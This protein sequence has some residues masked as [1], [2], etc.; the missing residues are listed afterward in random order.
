MIYVASALFCEAKPYIDTLGLKKD[1]AFSKIQVFKNDDV[2]L[3][4][5]GTGI[6]ASAMN[7][8]FV[9]G[10]YTPF[11][12][13]VFL[14]T[15]IC[16][17][18]DIG[19]TFVCNKVTL[20]SDRSRYFCPD[21]LYKTD[22]EER[23]LVTFDKPAAHIYEN[24]LADTEGYGLAAA[25]APYFSAERMFF[26]KTVSDRGDFEKVTPEYVSYLIGRNVEKILELVHSLPKP[27]AVNGL[28]EDE[29]REARKLRLSVSQMQRLENSLNYYRLKGG[30]ALALLRACPAA[31]TKQ[32]GRDILEYIEKTVI[33]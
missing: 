12:G 8:S 7:L 18:R 32:E 13:D 16:G 15:G 23:E 24:T 29:Q 31:N 17:G 1:E 9:L 5:T 27:E 19:D 22:L 3:T 6:L 28:S 33:S 2:I 10:K 26:I 20:H 30:N 14:N 25:T 11:P 21:M 4:V